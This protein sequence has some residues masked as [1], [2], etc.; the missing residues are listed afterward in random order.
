MPKP[1]LYIY[2][3]KFR[4]T[5]AKHKRKGEEVMNKNLRVIWTKSIAAI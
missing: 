3:S 5:F 1:D 2:L 4:T